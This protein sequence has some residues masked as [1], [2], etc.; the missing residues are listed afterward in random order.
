MKTNVSRFTV[1]SFLCFV[2]ILL[3]AGSGFSQDDPKYP[4]KPITFV[5]NVL[6]GNPTDLSC[7]L[8]AKENSSTL[9]PYE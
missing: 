4:R 5:N 1:S 6:A 8:I 9:M 2:I 7:R 3:I